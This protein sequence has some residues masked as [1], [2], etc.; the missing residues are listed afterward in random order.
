MTCLRMIT[1]PFHGHFRI[2]VLDKRTF[3]HK[4]ITHSVSEIDPKRYKVVYLPK[5]YMTER[6]LI[7]VI[8]RD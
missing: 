3:P 5:K 7:R 4:V 6:S 2:I 1:S 8:D